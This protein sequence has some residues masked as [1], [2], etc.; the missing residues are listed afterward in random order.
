MNRPT[1]LG[2]GGWD[3]IWW[4]EIRI[5]FNRKS[6]NEISSRPIYP[7]I[8]PQICVIIFRFGVAKKIV[9]K[10]TLP[11]AKNTHFG[12][13]FLRRL[14]YLI[15]GTVSINQWHCKDVVIL[16]LLNLWLHIFKLRWKN[17]DGFKYSP[18]NIF[19]YHF[20]C[21]SDLHMMYVSTHPC[22]EI[23]KKFRLS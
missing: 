8:W 19:K 23:W 16:W 2:G 20:P 10:K 5:G 3:Y 14:W 9:K 22:R 6:T 1:F 11:R 21:I 13:Y 18:K 4:I 12:I 17:L 15:W 7:A